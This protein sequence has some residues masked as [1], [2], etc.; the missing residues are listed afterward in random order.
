MQRALALRMAPLGDVGADC[1]SES[2]RVQYPDRRW[3]RPRK[4]LSATSQGLDFD[5]WLWEALGVSEKGHFKES[6]KTSKQLHL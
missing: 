4:V 2:R 6:E 5:L 3:D 1:L